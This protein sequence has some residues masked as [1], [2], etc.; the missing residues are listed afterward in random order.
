M[1]SVSTSFNE[2]KHY[3]TEI[4]SFIGE[5]VQS[6]TDKTYAFSSYHGYLNSLRVFLY[7]L[8]RFNATTRDIF[9]CRYDVVVPLIETIKE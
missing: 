3:L 7:N 4:I 9:G 5:R 1:K 2:R 8:T 6:E